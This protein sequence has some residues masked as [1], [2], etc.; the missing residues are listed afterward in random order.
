MYR[1]VH[2]DYE[3]LTGRLAQV[4]ILSSD[5]YLNKLCKCTVCALIH[6]ILLCGNWTRKEL[7]ASML[8]VQRMNTHLHTYAIC[9]LVFNLQWEH[10]SFYDNKFIGMRV[11]LY[12]LKAYLFRLVTLVT[13]TQISIWSNPMMQLNCCM[14][15]EQPIPSPS[16]C[17]DAPWHPKPAPCFSHWTRSLTPTSYYARF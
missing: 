13:Q 8:A 4:P 10:T 9:G 3:M 5:S 15:G 16:M 2:C 6:P 14:W 12:L 11:L 1:V 7:F 17:Q